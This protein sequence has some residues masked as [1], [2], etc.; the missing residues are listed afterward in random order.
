[1][2]IILEYL[3]YNLLKKCEYFLMI[4]FIIKKITVFILLFF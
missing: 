2:R 1:M 4:L 3:M